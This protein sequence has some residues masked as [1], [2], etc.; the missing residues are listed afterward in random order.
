MLGSQCSSADM[1]ALWGETVQHTVACLLSRP[2]PSRPPE[3]PGSSHLGIAHHGHSSPGNRIAT[4]ENHISR[5]LKIRIS[6]WRLN[7]KVTDYWARR[8]WRG[9]ETKINYRKGTKSL[10]RAG[11]WGIQIELYY[12]FLSS[13]FG[14]GRPKY[15]HRQSIL[16]FCLLFLLGLQHCFLERQHLPL[17]TAQRACVLD[18]YHKE[19]NQRWE[20]VEGGRLSVQA[21]NILGSKNTQL[22]KVGKEI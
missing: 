14:F 4:S 20:V 1:V 19:E 2:F 7:G 21:P 16:E 5:H 22:A 17:A 11:E 12:L 18:Q 15:Q 13:L 8:E 3:A 9:K 10:D 6:N